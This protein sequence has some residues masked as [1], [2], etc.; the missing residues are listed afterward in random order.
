MDK[1]TITSE[2][3][4]YIVE[5]HPAAGDSASVPRDQSLYELGIMDSFGVIELVD[6]VEKKWSIKILDSEISKEKFGGINKMTELIYEKTQA[7]QRAG[8]TS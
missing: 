4:R 1:H 2:L 5:N 6:F 8:S 3:L 7:R